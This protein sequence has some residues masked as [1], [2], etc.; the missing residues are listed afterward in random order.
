MMKL[1]S[2]IPCS[3]GSH[4]LLH[5]IFGNRTPG[6][7]ISLLRCFNSLVQNRPRQQAIE[8]LE[9]T[10][11]RCL[12]TGDDPACIWPGQWRTH[13]R[14]HPKRKEL[15]A[16]FDKIPPWKIVRW[17]NNLDALVGDRDCEEAVSFLSEFFWNGFLSDEWAMS[18]WNS[19]RRPRKKRTRTYHAPQTFHRP[20]FRLRTA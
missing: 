11:W 17:V 19:V 14:G 15:V 10:F 5:R 7:S 3:R 2:Q 9:Q 1:Q 18:I 4:V 16:V 8:Y 13:L 20:R 12:L 6:E